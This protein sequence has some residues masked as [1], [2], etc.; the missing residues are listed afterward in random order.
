MAGSTVLE[1]LRVLYHYPKEVRNRLFPGSY[2]EG[3]QAHLPSDT[4]SLTRPHIL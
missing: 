3:L 4:L 2:Q 1:D